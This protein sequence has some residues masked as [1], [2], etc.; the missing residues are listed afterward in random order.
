[1]KSN[2]IMTI[3]VN[4]YNLGAFKLFQILTKIDFKCV[5]EMAYLSKAIYESDKLYKTAL[6]TLKKVMTL[7]TYITYSL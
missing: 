1:M 7:L 5:L 2:Y 6:N 3:K 4:F